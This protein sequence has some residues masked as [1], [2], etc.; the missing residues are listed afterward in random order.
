MNTDEHNRVNHLNPSLLNEGYIYN[1]SK[2]RPVGIACR[3]NRITHTVER[4]SRVPLMTPEDK[5]HFNACFERCLAT[6]QQ[7]IQ[8][9][10]N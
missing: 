9:Q 10:R 5:L 7:F 1:D 6:A 8:S 3:V 2:G 4:P